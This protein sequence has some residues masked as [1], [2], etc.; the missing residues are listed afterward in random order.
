MQDSTKVL[1][2]NVGSNVKEID[3]RKGSIA[4]GL[5]V[6]LKSD[7]TI[8]LAAADGAKLGISAGKDLSDIGRTAIIR[9]GLAVPIQLTS[10]FTP[11]IGAQVAISDTTGKALAY[12]G[13]G[14]SYVNATW[15]SGVKSGVAEDGTLVDVALADFPG[16]L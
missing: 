8:S 5:C 3:N 14:D 6:H 2:G 15:V 12:T 4:A 9:K 11:T 13:S 7:D 10:A 16:G 1:M